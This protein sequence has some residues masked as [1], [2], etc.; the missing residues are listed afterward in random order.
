MY[1][2]VCVGHA[3]RM[4]MKR[5]DGRILREAGN[6]EANEIRVI[7]EQKGQPCKR[8]KGAKWRRGMGKSSRRE[9]KFIFEKEVL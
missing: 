8:K 9:T 5:E 4:K 1:L 6:R 7:R 3:T 2:H